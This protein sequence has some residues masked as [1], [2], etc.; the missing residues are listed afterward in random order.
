MLHN[1]GKTLQSPFHF[2]LEQAP[3]EI[4]R[5]QEC[6]FSV[7]AASFPMRL[8]HLLPEYTG[9]ASKEPDKP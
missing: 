4:I 5:K 7:T 6:L 9:S 2:F 3:N 8:S 1:D